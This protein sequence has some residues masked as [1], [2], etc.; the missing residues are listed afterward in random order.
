MSEHENK[1][2]RFDRGLI[3]ANNEQ[4]VTRLRAECDH[5]GCVVEFAD[6]SNITEKNTQLHAENEDFKEI[7]KIKSDTPMLDYIAAQARLILQLRKQIS[8]HAKS[9]GG[10]MLAKREELQGEVGRLRTGIERTRNVAEKREIQYRKAR[11]A[12]TASVCLQIKSMLDEI[13]PKED[14]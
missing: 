1:M 6:W 12:V 2:P 8:L 14:S 10:E 7:L 13:I 3:A 9:L 11:N 4:C 5:C